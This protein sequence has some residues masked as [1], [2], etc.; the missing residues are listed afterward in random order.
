VYVNHR[1]VFGLGI[2]DVRNAFELLGAA[3]GTGVLDRDQ[4]FGE[5]QR[6]GMPLITLWRPNPSTGEPFTEVELMNTIRVLIGDDRPIH[7]K[8]HQHFSAVEFAEDVLGFEQ[9][10]EE[11]TQA[12]HQQDDSY[13]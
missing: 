3:K 2:E 4:L 9:T 6:R 12:D 8:L 1:P 11:D 7:E 10:S 13:E 5:L